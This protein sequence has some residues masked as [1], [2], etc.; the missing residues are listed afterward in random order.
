MAQGGCMTNSAHSGLTAGEFRALTGLSPKALRVYA[1]R[2]LLTPADVDPASGYRTV[3]HDQL[4]AGLRLDFLRRAHV[5]LAEIDDAGSFSVA[6]WREKLALRRSMEDFYLDIAEH[7]ATRDVADFVTEYVDVPETHWVAISV[8]LGSPA[9][10]E[11]IVETFSDLAVVTPELDRRLLDVLEQASIAVEDEAWTMA[12]G[13][14][15]DTR[16]LFAHRIAAPLSVRQLRSLQEEI[17]KL[18]S[19]GGQLASGTLP[20]RTELTFAGSANADDP[21]AET[22]DAYLQVVAFAQH[23]TEHGL[24]PLHSLPRRRVASR[25]IFGGEPTD[26]FD[27]ASE[28]AG[29]PCGSTGRSQRLRGA[30][31]L[32]WGAPRRVPLRHAQA[33]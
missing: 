32:R 12:A 19:G 33:P 14:E 27:I 26:V 28:A 4:R 29:A 22:G 30:S 17:S 11:D 6:D 23:A 7:V 2:G 9:D 3:S 20:R 16:M 24:T 1:Q 10:P 5:P 31:S 15:T 13:G 21:V 18:A 8:D 25:S